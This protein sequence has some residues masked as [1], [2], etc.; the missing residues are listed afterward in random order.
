MQYAQRLGDRESV[1][2]VKESRGQLNWS[3]EYRVRGWASCLQEHNCSSNYSLVSRKCAG[4]HPYPCALYNPT[5]ICNVK[6]YRIL[7]PVRI[8]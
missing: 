4:F 1:A 8:R 5:T 7:W 2:H 6:V 3:S